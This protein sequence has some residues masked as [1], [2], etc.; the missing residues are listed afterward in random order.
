MSQAGII[1]VIQNNSS[2]PIN[3]Q[4]DSGTAV[5]LLNVLKIVGAGGITTSGLGNTITITGAGISP[6]L[7]LTGNSGGA[8]PPALDNWNIVGS[9]VAAGTNPVQ[10]SGSGSTIT[11]NVQRAQATASSA[12]NQAGISSFDSSVFTVDANGYV[13]ISG[14]SFAKTITGNSGGALSPSSANWDI[15]GSGSITTSGSGST[16]TAQLTGLT[17][18]AV[19][20]GA[21]TATITKVSPSA[22]SGVPLISQGSS[23]N[24]TFGT[25]AVAGGGTGVTTITGLVSGNGTSAFVGRTITGTSNQVTVTNGS[26]ATANPIISLPAT[27]YTNISFD[28]GS[29][30]LNSYSSGTWTPTI[31]T[32]GTAPTVTY[33]VQ[34][35]EYVKIGKFCYLGGLITFSSLS[36]GTGQIEVRGLPFAASGD[37]RFPLGSAGFKS[38]AYSGNY[39]CSQ[40]QDDGGTPRI[41]FTQ[42]GPSLGLAN[43]EIED[44]TSASEIN[45]AIC[46]Q[47]TS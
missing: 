37:F 34:R 2:I 44:F 38:V 30:T 22:T 40:L 47:T 28:S 7:T 18:Y 31:S 17:N 12:A 35:G 16:L 14:S 20:V 25:A 29:N 4:T 13:S 43:C 42:S 1:N 41:Q 5:S 39:T 23:S 24:P 46:Y 3:F 26:G 36:G 11:V 21:G 10:T 33:G 9:S 45:F 8:L 15:Q 32:N 19:L 6:S 27:I